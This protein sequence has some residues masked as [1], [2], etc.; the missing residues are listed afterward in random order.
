MVKDHFSAIPCAIAQIKFQMQTVRCVQPDI[1][2]IVGKIVR[3]R[4]SQI[5]IL[6]PPTIA[7]PIQV[8]IS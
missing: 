3:S 6:D 8:F 5:G 2:G 1:S 7:A 4:S